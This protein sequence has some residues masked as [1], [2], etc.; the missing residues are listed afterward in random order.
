PR[1]SGSTARAC[2]DAL[3]NT[4]WGTVGTLTVCATHGTL[5]LFGRPQ[6]DTAAANS[7]STAVVGHH[8]ATRPQAA[9]AFPFGRD[10]G[11]RPVLR[12]TCRRPGPCRPGR[13]LCRL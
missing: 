1:Q 12:P 7:H 6:S 11:L 3:G 2:R 9:S 8:E 4:V 13:R 5:T 10:R